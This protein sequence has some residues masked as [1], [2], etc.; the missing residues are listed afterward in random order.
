MPGDGI[1]MNID[2]NLIHLATGWDA[3]KYQRLSR[4]N[5]RLLWISGRRMGVD[6]ASSTEKHLCDH[7]TELDC[8]VTLISPGELD[9]Q[10][11]HHIPIHDWRIPGLTTISGARNASLI[12]EKNGMEDYDIVLIDW[13]YVKSMSR[14]I[15]GFKIPWAIVD[16]GPPQN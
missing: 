12:I 9:S 7:L 3:V 11:F 14:A 10:D 16:R 8:Q 13:R 4:T 2:P 15:S 5:M 6:L 1:Q